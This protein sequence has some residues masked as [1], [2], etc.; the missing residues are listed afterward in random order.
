MAQYRQEIDQFLEHFRM[1]AADIASV[2]S[3]FQRKVLYCAAFDPLARAAFGKVGSQRD[4]FV[5]LMREV[6]RWEAAERVSLPQLQLRLRENGRYRHRLYREVTR[7]IGLWDPSTKLDIS[8]SPSV[9]DLSSFT[10]ESERL[11]VRD[12]C[13]ADLFY[14]YRNNLVHEFREP[15]YGTDWS[16]KSRTPFYTSFIN[17]PREL[18]FPVEFIS[19]MYEQTLAGLKTHLVREKI[20][21]YN[22]FKFGSLW[23]TK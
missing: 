23:R 12:S 22:Q 7:Q 6:A 17:W 21:P 16:G 3:S 2:V 8:A 20:N 10:H 4:R 14:I 15:G 13:Y 19:N 1:Q 18:V 5:K 11:C 9:Q